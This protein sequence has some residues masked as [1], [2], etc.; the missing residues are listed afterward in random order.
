MSMSGDLKYIALLAVAWLILK[1]MPAETWTRL[2]MA[3]LGRKGLEGVGRVALAGQPDRITL[4]PRN[5]AP[6][7]PEAVSALEQLGRR[8]FASAGSFAVP[9]MKDLPVHFMVKPDECAVA[10]VYEH[11]Q[12]GVWCDITSKYQDGGSWLITNAPLGSGLEDRPG[13]LKVRAPGLTATAL[14]L[15]FAR[16]RKPGALVPVP[17]TA[18][19]QFFTDAYAEEMVWRK[20]RG[21]S[22]EEVRRAGMEPHRK[23]A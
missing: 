13:H 14:H 19:P 16:E 6:S 15:R 1:F 12:A 22:A 9:Q 21:L 17:A 8:G 20:G 10:A 3:V 4:V 2:I 11:P 18:V 5:G 7:R 23:S